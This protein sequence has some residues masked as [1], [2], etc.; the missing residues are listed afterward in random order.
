MCVDVCVC[1]LGRALSLE[2]NKVQARN[3][4][5]ATGDRQVNGYIST[6]VLLPEQGAWNCM[7]GC[8]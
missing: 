7:G 5:F 3:L 4:R 2:I 6:R 1:L 8:R